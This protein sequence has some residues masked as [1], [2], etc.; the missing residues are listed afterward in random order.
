M[1]LKQGLA[2]GLL[3]LFIVW[4][5][6]HRVF[7]EVYLINP[8]K[9]FGWAMYC[10]PAPGA[11]TNILIKED[12]QWR[13]ISGT[14]PMI[15]LIKEFNFKKANRGKLQGGE[16]LLQQ[17]YEQISFPVEELQIVVRHRHYVWKQNRMIDEVSTYQLKN[18]QFQSIPGP[19]EKNP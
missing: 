16:E 8:W 19:S 3:L 1:R 6:G 17:V 13:N 15:P 4:P 10:V 12:N 5:I 11:G 14:R 9:Y 18:G 2:S 7:S